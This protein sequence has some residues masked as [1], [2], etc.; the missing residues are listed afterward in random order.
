MTFEQKNIWIIGASSGI[1]K[2]L[3]IELGRRGARL[4]L[5]ARNGLALET[6]FSQ[7]GKGAIVQ[8][9]DVTDSAAFKA[10]AQAVSQKLGSLDG[11][12]L[13]S[14]VY[15]PGSVIDNDMATIKNIVDVNLMGALNC[16]AA[17]VPLLRAQK[18][19]QLVLCGSVAG[20]RGLP[21]AQ[22]YSA[23]KA[24]LIN[25]AESLHAEEKKNGIDVRLVNPGFVKTPMTEKNTFPMPFMITA[26]AA[27]KTIAD[28]LAGRS[29]EICFPTRMK[30]L[31]K[32]LK[33]LP[34]W[35]YFKIGGK[36]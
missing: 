35:L 18:K 16:L 36:L 3:A 15:T 27:A 31:M 32:L 8:P 10:A 17:V 5:S 4:A 21:H 23:T 12:I 30:L 11:V 13:M 33:V 25:L 20:Y 14:G 22:P 19:S 26:E 2:A 7:L 6:L 34:D 9:L 28:G 29:F 1:G 24:A